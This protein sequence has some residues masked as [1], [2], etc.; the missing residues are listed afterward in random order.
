[1]RK[2]STAPFSAARFAIRRS[3][4]AMV[5]LAMA[6]P[7]AGFA[8]ETEPVDLDQR[9]RDLGLFSR[10][11]TL[12]RA[13]YVEPVDE[14]D[15]L[16]GAM[17]G[18]LLE[19][20]PHSAFMEVEAYEDMQVD[21][22]GEF[23]GLG[24]E[25][26]KSQGEAIEVVSPIEGTPASR[27][28]I[29]ARD[30][31]VAICPTEVPE[32]W[33]TPCRSTRSMSLE[34]AVDLMRGR[35]GTSITIDVMRRGFKRPRPFEI[36][37]DVVQVESVAGRML[38]PGYAYVRVRSFQERTGEDVEQTVEKLRLES[39]DGLR[40]MVLDLRDNPGGLLDQAVRVA[41]MWL[42]EGL[43]VYTQGR[44]E[45]ERQDFRADADEHDGSYPIVVL[46][47]EGS[48]SA[49]EIVAGAL[50]DQHRGLILGATTFG[51]GSV[52]TVYPLEDGSGLR[53]T[54]ALYYTPSGRS[55]QEVGI[56][57]DIEVASRLADDPAESAPE[58]RHVRESDLE[59]HFS[60][61]DAEPDSEEEGDVQESEARDPQLNRALEVL[62]SWDYFDR[63]KQP[64][65]KPGSKS[66]ALETGRSS[67]PQP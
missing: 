62:K 21:T 29:R 65:L 55:I 27:A 38:E 10:V 50:Q 39:G 1:M 56:V 37:R 2:F 63:L 13:N 17:H 53:L 4:V 35:R 14:S 33:D 24:I 47:N 20:D 48:A 44:H 26:T 54:T 45:S 59:G 31:I 61:Q 58:L 52:Q 60:H 64:L 11:L 57:P 32:G 8:T 16:R 23:H 22:R 36:V 66:A 41:D 12:V 49:S 9:Y 67:N 46:V 5:I 15:L 25:I 34:E 6:W 43:V 3:V 19:L 42:S 30:R 7:V 28:G 51:K 18:L 40:G